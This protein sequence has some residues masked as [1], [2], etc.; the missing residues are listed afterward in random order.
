MKI[1]YLVYQRF[2]VKT[3]IFY[4]MGKGDIKTRR[5]KISNGSFGKRRP[6][7]SKAALK[8]KVGDAAPKEVEQKAVKAKK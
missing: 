4:T 5:G 2:I 6:H 7:L 1:V 8:P 3:K